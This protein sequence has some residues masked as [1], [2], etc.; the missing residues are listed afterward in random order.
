MFEYLTV[1]TEN[2]KQ[3]IASLDISGEDHDMKLNAE[4]GIYTQFRPF[5]V[6]KINL[7]I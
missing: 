2:L 3:I 6:N 7:Q 4:S 5:I 1:T